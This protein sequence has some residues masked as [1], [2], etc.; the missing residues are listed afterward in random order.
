M[1]EHTDHVDFWRGF[2][3]GSLVGLVAAAYARGDFRR[4]LSFASGLEPELEEPGHSAGL[5][6]SLAAG[7]VGNRI[8][9]SSV[10]ST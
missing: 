6:P 10:E 5:I 4:M 7:P 8:P 2:V 3:V 1:A 9:A